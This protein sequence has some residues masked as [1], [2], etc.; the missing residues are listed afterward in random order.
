VCEHKRTRLIVGKGNTSFTCMECH[1]EL[2][3]VMPPIKDKIDFVCSRC[4]ACR[5]AFCDEEISIEGLKGYC[6]AC[7]RK[8][9]KVSK[10]AYEETH[11]D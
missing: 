9:D 11:R 3:R 10:E 2:P 5:C 1:I 6:R 4:G 8:T 7:R